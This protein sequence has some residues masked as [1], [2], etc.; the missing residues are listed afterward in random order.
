MRCARC[1]G[2]M[3]KERGAAGKPHLRK[4]RD[5]CSEGPAP[6][7]GVRHLAA[8][9]R[10]GAAD[11]P[12]RKLVSRHSSLVS[13]RQKARRRIFSL[14]TFHFSLLLF[15]PAGQKKKAAFRPPSVR[16]L[17]RFTCAASGEE[18]SPTRQG[19]YRRGPQAVK[20]GGRGD[21]RPSSRR[22]RPAS[23]RNDGGYR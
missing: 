14:F 12:H 15:L 1:A 17:A 10:D 7:P 6:L 22:T 20:P 11:R 4:S 16:F 18:P 3:N 5:A 21:G 19:F 8:P 2:G 23:G 9:K 13:A